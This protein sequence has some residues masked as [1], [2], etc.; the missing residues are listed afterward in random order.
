MYIYYYY[1]YYYYYALQQYNVMCYIIMC[2][3]ILYNI[4]CVRVHQGGTNRGSRPWNGL[5]Y[6]S[7][8]D[9]EIL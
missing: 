4:A 8:Y 5:A 6:I 3:I 2:I 9:F 1:Y 7:E